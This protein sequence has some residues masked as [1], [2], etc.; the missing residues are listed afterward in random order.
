MEYRP[1]FIASRSALLGLTAA[2]LRR[3][4]IRAI[5]LDRSWLSE[6]GP[7]KASEELIPIIDY[8]ED[9]E[10]LRTLPQVDIIIA[11]YRDIGIQCWSISQ[12]RVVWEYVAQEDKHAEQKRSKKSVDG[13]RRG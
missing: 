11:V 1:P 9:Y 5:K 3:E 13:L 4:I 6:S 7:K 12:K 2:D 10:Y 8:T